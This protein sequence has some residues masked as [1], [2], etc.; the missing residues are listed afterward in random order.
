MIFGS[1]IF[2]AEAEV[3]VAEYLRS[4]VTFARSPEVQK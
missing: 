4:S 1:A 2:D 3:E